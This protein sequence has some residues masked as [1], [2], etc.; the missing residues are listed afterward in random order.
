MKHTI[1]ITFAVLAAAAVTNL[2]ACGGRTPNK[3]SALKPAAEAQSKRAQP[4]CANEIPLETGDMTLITDDEQIP[5]G[6]YVIKQLASYSVQA[7][8]NDSFFYKADANDGFK[9]HVEC[10]GIPATKPSEATAITSGV[11]A[12][13]W[14]EFPSRKTSPRN[15]GITVTFDNGVAGATTDSIE[16]EKAAKPAPLSIERK[17]I[18]PG[19]FLSVRHYLSTDHTIVTRVKIEGDAGGGHNFTQ[20]NHVVMQVE[21]TG[22]AP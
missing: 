14:I 1:R 11:I 13:E 21:D 8:T 7:A 6:H 2:P 19:I 17:E 15:R 18:K 10:N 22:A 12:D 9:P 4:T 3:S 16:K 20:F 5:P